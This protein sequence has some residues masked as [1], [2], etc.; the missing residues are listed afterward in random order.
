MLRELVAFGCACVRFI[1]VIFL[2]LFFSSFDLRACTYSL[3]ARARTGPCFLFRLSLIR[4]N[5][6]KLVL[7]FRRR[8]VFYTHVHRTYVQCAFLSCACVVVRVKQ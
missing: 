2:L 6:F 8:R 4:T 7:F 1:L 3:V 5:I